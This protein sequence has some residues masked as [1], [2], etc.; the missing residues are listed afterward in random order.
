MVPSCD[1]IHN[2][3]VIP[4]TGVEIED[5]QVSEL[6]LHVPAS[7]RVQLV[8]NNK[9]TIATSSF[10]GRLSLLDRLVFLPFQSFKIEG[11]DIAEGNA[12]II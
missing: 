6:T 2:V 1:S 9:D 5:D 4:F 11:V 10:R 3:W 7:I 8:I 12:G